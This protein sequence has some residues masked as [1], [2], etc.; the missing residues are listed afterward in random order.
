MIS[1]QVA[2]PSGCRGQ[3]ISPPVGVRVLLGNIVMV[4][5]G[6]VVSV[7]VE[8]GV[9]VAESVEV[10]IFVGILV[11]IGVNVAVGVLFG[12]LVGEGMYV[13]VGVRVEI[14]RKH[15]RVLKQYFSV[16][17]MPPQIRRHKVYLMRKK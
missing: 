14:G 17:D 11:G 6:V 1:S 9:L 3:Y 2:S 12:V 5:L 10:G 16:L 4:I 7:G 13:G 8:V 15:C